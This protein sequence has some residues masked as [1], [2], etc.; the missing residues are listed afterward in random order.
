MS[1]ASAAR[2]FVRDVHELGMRWLAGLVWLGSAVAVILMN[3]LWTS[4]GAL[5]ASDVLVGR[6]VPA[7]Q[8]VALQEI[9]HGVWDE[10]LKR[11][12]DKQ[13]RVNYTAWKAS[14]RDSA[15][16]DTYLAHLSMA[17]MSSTD[18]VEVKLAYWTNAYNA[19][20]IKGILREYP[21]S[22]IRNH[23]AKLFGYNI[24]KNLK[25]QV[26]GRRVSLDAMEHEILRKLGEPRIHFAIVCASIGCPR[27][28][29]EAYVADR[30]DAQLTTNARVFFADSSKFRGEPDRQR[31]YLSPILNWFATDFGRSQ[32]DQ[33]K[34]ISPWVPSEFKSLLTSGK[35]RVSYLSYDWDLND[36]K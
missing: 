30:L 9:E 17:R 18:A 24:W 20:T 11:Y 31:V 32:V 14:A 13:G 8:R 26:D 34:T 22:S 12:V 10:L 33:M 28:L 19:V 6:V 21:T 29:D 25:L 15:R 36:R 4:N 3:T 1:E 7:E 27:L 5:A 16:L 2:A 35:A 23:T